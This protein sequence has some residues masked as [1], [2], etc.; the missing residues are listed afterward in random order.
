VG[1]E[2]QVDRLRLDT[3]LPETLEEP[4]MVAAVK[5]RKQGR[6]LALTDTG[7]DQDRSAR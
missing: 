2:H 7:I 5:V 6:L 1:A 3:G 4:A